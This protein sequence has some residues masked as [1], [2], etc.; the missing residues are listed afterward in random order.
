MLNQFLEINLSFSAGRSQLTNRIPPREIPEGCYDC[1]DGFYNPVSRVIVDYEHKFLRNAGTCAKQKWKFLSLVKDHTQKC[2]NVLVANFQLILSRCCWQLAL[3]TF[4]WH[5][6]SG[7][8]QALE[9]VNTVSRA[10]H[11]YT[12]LMQ[13]GFESKGQKRFCEKQSGSPLLPNVVLSS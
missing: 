13:N 8:T 7:G 11:N 10:R 12:M 3:G 5:C 2:R 6:N 9:F 4:Y 1:G